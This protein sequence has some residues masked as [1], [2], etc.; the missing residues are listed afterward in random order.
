MQS[1]DSVYGLIAFAFP[2]APHLV[3]DNLKTYKFELRAKDSMQ[4][5][6]KSR[7]ILISTI[8]TGT[9]DRFPCKS[10]INTPVAKQQ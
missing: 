4:R 7:Q 8:E 5:T 10:K 9:V 6:I 3:N 1:G 2:S